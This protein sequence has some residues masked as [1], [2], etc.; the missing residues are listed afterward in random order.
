M[1]YKCLLMAAAITALPLLSLPAWS[2]VPSCNYGTA[3]SWVTQP[4]ARALTSSS[5]SAEIDTWDFTDADDG[6]LWTSW[7]YYDSS[8]NELSQTEGVNWSSCNRNNNSW[9]CYAIWGPNPLSS[10]APDIYTFQVTTGDAPY[11]AASCIETSITIQDAPTAT[12][13]SG[14]AQAGAVTNFIGS[15]T[16]DPNAVNPTLT[17]SWD[18]GD[19]GN[20]SLQNPTHT[21]ATTGNYTVTLTT[22]DGYFNSTPTTAQVTV[23]TYAPSAVL[24]PVLYQ[25]GN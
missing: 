11:A 18:F 4:P 3:L 21:Y 5:Q 22:N 1:R 7:H 19:G 25:I 9:T 20:S 16:I 8:G 6:N 17:Y 10:F 2:A 15:G 24:V 14:L 12:M 13:G 23:V